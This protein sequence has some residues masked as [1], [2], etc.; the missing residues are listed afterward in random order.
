[1]LERIV[2]RGQEQGTFRADADPRIASWMLYGALE[3]VLTGWVLGRLPDDTTA[4][5]AA[6]R[7]V[8]ATLVGGLTA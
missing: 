3:E 8:V 2:R 4:V 7:E 1:M 6:E 5:A